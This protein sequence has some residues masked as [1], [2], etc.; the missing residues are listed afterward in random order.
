MKHSWTVA[1]LLAVPPVASGQVRKILNDFPGR[2]NCL[3]FSPD[4]KLLA[5]NTPPSEGDNNALRLWDV[6]TGKELC[7]LGNYRLVGSALTFTPD[8]KTLVCNGSDDSL[9]LWDLA[10]RKVRLTIRTKAGVGVAL[11]VS[12]DSKLLA[13]GG[14]GDRVVVWDLR[15]GKVLAAMG[16]KE[17]FDPRSAGSRF[18]CVVFSPD[19]KL[20]ATSNYNGEVALWD[21][22]M[23]KK[24]ATLTKHKRAVY[25]VAFAPDGK[26]LYS[27]GRDSLLVSWDVAPAKERRSVNLRAQIFVPT[28]TAL[29]PDGATLA[30]LAQNHVRLVDL[31]TGTIRE[32]VDWQYQDGHQWCVAF[33]PDGKLLATGSGGNPRWNTVDLYNVPPPRKLRH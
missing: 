7:C 17:E 26:T 9:H 20:L 6:A 18:T 25:N 22:A 23:G 4:G 28:Y 31:E 13:G 33:S 30:V 12:S 14:Y 21:V 29:S 5:T 8:G 32:D 10:T 15:T 11:A 3:A 27:L 24:R 19:G 16:P 1:I 2:V